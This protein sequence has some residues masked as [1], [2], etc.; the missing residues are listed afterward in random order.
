[1]LEAQTLNLGPWAFSSAVV[2]VLAGAMTA[3]G[4]I[5]WLH[6]RGRASAENA[7]W[8]VLGVAL[9]AARLAYVVRWWPEY[10]THPAS[11]AN[12]RDGGCA[13]W[14]GG[15]ALAV[16]A[17]LLGWRRPPLRVPLAWSLAGGLLVA[18]F[19]GLLVQRLAVSV[20][21]PLPELVLRDLDGRRVPTGK[22]TGQPTVLNLWA[23]WCGPCRREMPVLAAA[24]QHAPGARFVFV[25]QGESAAQIRHFLAAEQLRLG[26][27][28]LDDGL[29]VAAHYNVRAYPTTL[30]FDAQGHLRDTHVG[31]LSAATLADALSRLVP[32]SPT[33]DAGELP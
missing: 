9:L 10:A 31:E 29:Q 28:L 15:A 7:L 6:R 13:G 18:G 33:P 3:F 14:A 11:I 8:L 30:F 1:V 20:Q 25:N 23:T 12:L 32:S 19:V 27:V 21:A 24:Q 22:W 5:G 4:I 16:G 2:V 17:L 26:N